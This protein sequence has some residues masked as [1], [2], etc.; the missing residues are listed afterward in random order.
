MEHKTMAAISAGPLD[1]KA[2]RNIAIRSAG[3]FCVFA[4]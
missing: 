4:I 2:D 3:T 1:G